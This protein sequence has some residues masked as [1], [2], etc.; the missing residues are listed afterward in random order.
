M[1][2]ICEVLKAVPEGFLV[3]SGDDALTLSAMAVG[4]R[5]V[6]SVASNEVPGEMARLVEAAERNDFAAAREIHARLLPLMLANFAES[7]PIPVKAAM[8]QMG[9]LE[10][11]YRLPMVPPRAET[12]EK[13]R[14]VLAA[15]SLVPAAAH[16]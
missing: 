15:L 14:R 5:G 3:L 7:N 12:R 1:T 16:A 8:A 10:E 11:S 2:Q 4:A 13:V 9:L 6:V